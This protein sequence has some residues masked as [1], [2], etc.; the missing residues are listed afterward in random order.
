MEAEKRVKHVIR[1]FDSSIIRSSKR[2]C[3][4]ESMRDYA[5]MP[6]NGEVY[7]V[8][9][10]GYA[11]ISPNEAI[12]KIESVP[13]DGRATTIDILVAGIVREGRLEREAAAIYQ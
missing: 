10:N 6:E 2:I 8:E 12:G 11:V 3:L 4:P 13:F 7:V 9:R 1:M 5:G